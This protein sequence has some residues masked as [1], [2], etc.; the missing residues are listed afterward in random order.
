MPSEMRYKGCS[1]RCAILAAPWMRYLGFSLRSSFILPFFIFFFYLFLSSPVLFLLSFSVL[2]FSPLFR[3]FFLPLF[4]LPFSLFCSSLFSPSLKFL[5]LASFLTSSLCSLPP[6]SSL[7][8]YRGSAP[9]PLEHR[10]SAFH[11]LGRVITGRISD[12]NR[13]PSAS[14]DP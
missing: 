8:F 10:C 4:S 6:F 12:S 9:H 13:R 1:S 2:L 14:G 11:R 5:F 7:L 3:S